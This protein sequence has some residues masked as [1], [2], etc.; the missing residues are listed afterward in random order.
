MS[1]SS[2]RG[3]LFSLTHVLHPMHCLMF[4]SA[5]L[6]SSVSAPAALA[7]SRAKER[8][9]SVFL[10]FLGDPET[11]STLTLGISIKSGVMARR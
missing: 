8:S 11:P 5:R 3:H 6:R 10:P 1:S 9:F 2:S 7:A 4:S